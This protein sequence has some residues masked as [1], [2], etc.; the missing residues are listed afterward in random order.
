MWPTMVFVFHYGHGET[1]DPVVRF[2]LT[3]QFLAMGNGPDVLVGMVASH[4]R[5]NQKRHLII[6]HNG[7]VS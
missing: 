2:L 3:W 4:Y 7:C 6:S 1:I 5:F